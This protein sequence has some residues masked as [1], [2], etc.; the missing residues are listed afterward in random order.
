MPA[1][2]RQAMGNVSSRIISHW[3]PEVWARQVEC[4][5]RY[6]MAARLKA[7]S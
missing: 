2:R 7:S 1:Q 6:A 4:A 3:T 5:V